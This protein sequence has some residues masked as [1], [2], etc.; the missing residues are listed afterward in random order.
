[1]LLEQIFARED[2]SPTL[3]NLGSW[4][5]KQR[6]HLPL[7]WGLLGKPKESEENF[8]KLLNWFNLINIYIFLIFI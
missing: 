5:Y 1:M 7:V 2:E 6:I 8:S 3:A 4:V